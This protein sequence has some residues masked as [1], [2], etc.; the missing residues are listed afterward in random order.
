[1]NPAGRRPAKN[2]NRGPLLVVAV[3]LTL[4]VV[5]FLLGALTT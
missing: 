1:M 5:G 2:P 4:G 3:F